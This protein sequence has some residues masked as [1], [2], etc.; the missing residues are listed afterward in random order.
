VMALESRTGFSR[1]ADSQSPAT[2][3]MAASEAYH[4]RITA[5]EDLSRTAGQSPTSHVKYSPD[6]WACPLKE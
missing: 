6:A 1:R 5:L 3:L 4:D 2:G